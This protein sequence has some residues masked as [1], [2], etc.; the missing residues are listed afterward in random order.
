MWLELFAQMALCALFLFV[1]GFLL[2]S[3]FVRSR[4]FALACA[5]GASLSLYALLGYGFAKASVSC[6]WYLLAFSALAVGGVVWLVGRR[7]GIARAAVTEPEHSRRLKSFAKSDGALLALYAVTGLAAVGVFFLSALE[8]PDSFLQ[9]YDSVSHLGTIRAFLESGSWSSAGTALY[10]DD[11]FVPP[12]PTDSFYPSA[13]HVLVAMVV[14]ALPPSVGAG[15]NAVNAVFVALVFP[16]GMFFLLRQVLGC[17]RIALA[18]GAVCTMAFAA[19]PWK[20]MVWGPLFP[21]LTSFCLVP[22]AAALFILAV[23]QLERRSI[24]PAVRAALLFAFALVG[25]ALSQP[26][27]VFTLMVFLV[28]FCTFEVGRLVGKRWGGAHPVA[29]S[30]AAGA[31]FLVVAAL[32]WRFCYRLPFMASVVSFAWPPFV[33]RLQAVENVLML[34]MRETNPQ[35]LLGLLVIIGAV[36]LVIRR[37]SPWLV[38]SYAAAAGMYVVCAATS[39][40]LKQMLCGFWYADPMRIAAMVAM[41]AIPLASF[42][43][44]TV[45]RAVR[46]GL[47]RVVKKAASPVPFIAGVVVAAAIMVAN[48]LTTPNLPEDAWDPT[49]FGGI[50]WNLHYGYDA[51]DNVLDA[52]EQRFLEEMQK[53]VGD[54]ELII[55]EPNDGSAFAYGIDGLNL[56]YRLMYNLSGATE[57]EESKVIRDRLDELASDR[58]VQKAV[59]DLGADYVLQLDHN[60]AEGNGRYLWS[61][62]KSQWTG[63][64]DIDDDTPGFELVLSEGDMRLYKIVK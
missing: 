57:S 47:S 41:F 22:A 44:A 29:V 18:C 38:A 36:A 26:N 59:T 54:D 52:D 49:A 46:A 62:D 23:R 40:S 8:A 20:F 16:A 48:F 43:L 5:P 15:V 30:V 35:L 24:A 10:V 42:G 63:I 2:A 1:P 11:S 25:I 4:P 58:E 55:N 51:D 37:R 61:Y 33:G 17:D 56:Y 45:V 32:F 53:I 19:F 9:E 64:D 7:W 60:G 14:D 31:A 27:A 28:P 6:S 21:N 12:Y 3:F 50:Q 13:W 34:S 39:G